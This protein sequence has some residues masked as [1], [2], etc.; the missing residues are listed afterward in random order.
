MIEARAAQFRGFAAEIHDD[1]LFDLQNHSYSHAAAKA[2]AEFAMLAALGVRMV[3]AFNSYWPMPFR[4]RIRMTIENVHRSEDKNIFFHRPVP[5]VHGA[6]HRRPA[7][8]APQR[9]LRREHA[10]QPVSLAHRRQGPAEG[11]L[12]RRCPPCGT[13]PAVRQSERVLQTRSRPATMTAS[14]WETTSVAAGERQ[15]RRG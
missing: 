12:A 14:L 4:K 3:N 9:R 7:R 2:P 5:G 11:D 6:P 8:R 1:P 10:L 15:L 13:A